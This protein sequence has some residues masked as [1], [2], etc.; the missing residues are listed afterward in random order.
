MDFYVPH[1]R[2]SK[3]VRYDSYRISQ[4]YLSRTYE[5][6][7]TDLSST[8]LHYI[9]DKEKFFYATRLM[10]KGFSLSETAK[11]VGVSVPTAFSWRHN[12]LDKLKNIEVD[13]IAGIVETDDTLFLHSQ[14][15]NQKI[16]RMPW[17]RGDK[18]KKHGISSEQVC[19]LVARDRTDST[20][21]EVTTLCCSPA[22][23]IDKV[24]GASLAKGSIFLTGRQLSF[25][26]FVKNKDLGYQ[27][28]DLN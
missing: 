26:Y 10:L 28:I 23:Q 4:C 9:H 24:L 25:R 6:T 17:K 22:E 21:T 13:C 18:S 15:G 7:F 8:A 5:K 20:I 14:R 2:S 1:Y 27:R 19:V 11:K 12:I 3:V 16:D